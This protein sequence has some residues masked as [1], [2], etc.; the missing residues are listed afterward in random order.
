[1]GSNKKLCV[2]V[3]G[4]VA[5]EGSHVKMLWLLLIILVN[6]TAHSQAQMIPANEPE[7]CWPKEAGGQ[8][9]ASNWVER[10]EG[11]VIT[12]WCSDGPHYIAA[13]P[14]DK[15]QLTRNVTALRTELRR[16]Y[17]LH[18][19]ARDRGTFL[20]DEAKAQLASTKPKEQQ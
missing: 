6:I 8:G 15:P 17:V 4:V 16:L 3:R 19:Y 11:V 18:A 5:V 14:I 9:E 1:M 7:L 10:K 12:W 20:V 13:Y 2:Q